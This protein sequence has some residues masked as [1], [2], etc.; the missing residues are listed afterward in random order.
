M[1]LN[2]ESNNNK[3]EEFIKNKT[4]NPEKLFFK[5][6]ESLDWLEQNEAYKKLKGKLNLEKKSSSIRRILCFG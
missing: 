1:E 4:E 6:T 3:K 2:N 5:K